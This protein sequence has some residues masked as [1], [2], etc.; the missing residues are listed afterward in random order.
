MISTSE[1]QTKMSVSFHLKRTL[2]TGAGKGI[3]PALALRLAD[4]GAKVNAI[5]RTESDLDNLKKGCGNIDGYNIDIADW[6]KT[7][8]VVENIGPIDMLVNNAAVA[9]QTPFLD[10]TKGQLD[11]EFDK[12]QGSVQYITGSRERDGRN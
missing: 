10:V 5:S 9:I 8:S 6:D 1:I 7:R 2:V 12:F 4:M 11:N 3:G